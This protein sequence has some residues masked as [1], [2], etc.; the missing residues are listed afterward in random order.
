L[1]KRRRYPQADVEEIQ[2]GKK[3][4]GLGRI[5]WG[6]IS[7]RIGRKQTIILM[8]ILQGITMLSTYHVFVHFGLEYG[9]VVAAAHS[10]R[11]QS[12]RERSRCQRLNFV[13]SSRTLS[14][15]RDGSATI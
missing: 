5:A 4:N 3:S 6:S 8:A 14:N 7:D 11:C 12:S 15:R 13:D 1:R 2:R 10:I 9:F